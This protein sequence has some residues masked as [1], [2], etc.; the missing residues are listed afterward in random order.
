MILGLLGIYHD[1]Q[2]FLVELFSAS[3]CTVHKK[4]RSG[5]DKPMDVLV[6]FGIVSDGNSA[7]SRV[8]V[9]GKFLGGF[10][11]CLG[12]LYYIELL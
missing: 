4:H 1:E 10:Y 9:L 7:D 12:P 2:N 5:H 3:A 11:V 6:T 8:A